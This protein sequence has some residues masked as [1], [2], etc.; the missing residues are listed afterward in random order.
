MAGKCLIYIRRCIAIDCYSRQRRYEATKSI[1][2]RKKAK[3]KQAVLHKWRGTKAGSS[4][5]LLQTAVFHGKLQQGHRDKLYYAIVLSLSPPPLKP[6]SS[7]LNV[8][9]PSLPLPL[10]LPLDGSGHC[11]SF[12]KSFVPLH[13]LT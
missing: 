12:M 10:L 13:P 6:C 11:L 2:D 3:K 1:T 4:D 9:S 5:T 7:L 8:F